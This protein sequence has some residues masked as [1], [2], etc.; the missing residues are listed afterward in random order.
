MEHQSNTTGTI[1][2]AQRMGGAGKVLA[3]FFAGIAAH[4]LKQERQ[5]QAARLQSMYYAMP[6]S[7]RRDRPRMTS[8]NQNYT[9]G[10]PGHSKLA[11]RVAKGTVGVRHGK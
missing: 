6:N 8:D 4:N 3:A 10:V 2:F 9:K 1:S 11:K 5:Q 7:T